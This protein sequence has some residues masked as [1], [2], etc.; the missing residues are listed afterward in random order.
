MG[1][2]FLAFAL[3]FGLITLFPL[4]AKSDPSDS[5]I[6]QM[7]LLRM[8]ER[9][10]FLAN[11]SFGPSVV[12]PQPQSRYWAVVGEA[13]SGAMTGHMKNHVFV[14]AVRLIC[15]DDG[16]A[17]CWRLEKLAIDN[18]IVLDRGGEL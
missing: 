7:A 10:D 11:A 16:K 3:L 1:M 12:H 6:I 18:Q 4:P 5:L 14:A 15:D 8:V 2:R 9:L 13:V 17:D